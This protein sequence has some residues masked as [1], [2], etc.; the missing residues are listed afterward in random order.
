MTAA[1]AF[2]LT[3]ALYAAARSIVRARRDRAAACRE[4][5]YLSDGVWP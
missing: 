1:F 4:P 3:L 5:E 2:T